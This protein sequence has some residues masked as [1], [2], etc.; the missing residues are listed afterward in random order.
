MHIAWMHLLCLPRV[1]AP[2]FVLLAYPFSGALVE[3]EARADIVELICTLTRPQLT[4]PW[5]G[6]VWQDETGRNCNV[7]QVQVQVQL[8]AMTMLT[9]PQNS[10]K[11]LEN[12]PPP[13][14]H[15]LFFGPQN[16][17]PSIC[18]HR[19]HRLAPQIDANKQKAA[20]LPSLEVES[21]KADR[22]LMPFQMVFRLWVEGWIITQKS[23]R[24]IYIHLYVIYL[25]IFYIFSILYIQRFICSKTHPYIQMPLFWNF[26][27][28]IFYSRCRL[29][30]I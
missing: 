14:P 1:S 12:T 29:V 7:S 3:G 23:E 20:L 6:I 17:K 19:P 11:E 2:S 30:E 21:P 24:F 8:T 25:N 26:V 10:S 27:V 15:T 9:S 4:I 16:Q 22:A 28:S 5:H 18:P 13:L